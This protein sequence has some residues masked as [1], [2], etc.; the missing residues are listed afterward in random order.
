MHFI[1]T[2]SQEYYKNNNV[3]ARRREHAS[4][5]RATLASFRMLAA[6]R[7]RT[8]RF[9]VTAAAAQSAQ[10]RDGIACTASVA[11][12]SI[13]VYTIYVASSHIHTYI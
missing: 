3:C 6:R 8:M 13:L 5:A 9:T 2:Q 1:P 7:P 12:Y 10:P 4:T 11:Y